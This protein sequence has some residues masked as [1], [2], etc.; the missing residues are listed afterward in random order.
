LN[1]R[2]DWIDTTSE[3]RRRSQSL[4]RL[5]GHERLLGCG[6]EAAKGIGAIPGIACDPQRKII[7]HP[8]SRKRSQSHS[9]FQCKDINV[10]PLKR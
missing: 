10:R 7:Q 9:Y 3:S 6:T 5:G 4:S 1:R 2:A 8:A